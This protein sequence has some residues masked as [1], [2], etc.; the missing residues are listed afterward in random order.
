[1]SQQHKTKDEKKSD[2]GKSCKS[3]MSKLSKNV[4]EMSVNE[5]LAARVSAT[6]KPAPKSEISEV[7]FEESEKNA[8]EEPKYNS[9]VQNRLSTQ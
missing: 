3:S 1:M 4:L 9:P 8:E 2:D 5:L 7:R 6:P